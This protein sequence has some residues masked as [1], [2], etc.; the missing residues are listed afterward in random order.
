MA[1]DLQP[2]SKI[3]EKLKVAENGHCGSEVYHQIS[4][5]WSSSLNIIAITKIQDGS[6]SAAAML[7]V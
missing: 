5:D 3:F 7:D 6:R 1:A 4:K 2:P